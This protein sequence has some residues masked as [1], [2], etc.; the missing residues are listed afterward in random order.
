MLGVATQQCIEII[1]MLW[2]ELWLNSYVLLNF[3]NHVEK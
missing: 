3:F 2:I 1:D